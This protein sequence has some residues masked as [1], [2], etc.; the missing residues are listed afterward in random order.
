MCFKRNHD[1]QTSVYINTLQLNLTPTNSGQITGENLFC[2]H[3][4]IVRWHFSFHFRLIQYV[5][6]FFT[7]LFIDCCDWLT[8]EVPG[9]LTKPCLQHLQKDATEGRCRR[10]LQKDATE[11]RYRRTLQKDAISDTLSRQGKLTESWKL[12]RCK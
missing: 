4:K 5:F 6:F 12:C 1:Y 7:L 8:E 3:N 10:T 9:S 2:S 11:G